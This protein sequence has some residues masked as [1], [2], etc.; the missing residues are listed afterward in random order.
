MAWA[1]QLGVSAM[2]ALVVLLVASPAAHAQ[3]ATGGGLTVTVGTSSND[4]PVGEAFYYGV[5]VSN[6]GGS[7]VSA[8]VL[9]V[10]FPPS[11]RSQGAVPP[12]G[13]IAAPLG[14]ACP[15][16]NLAA[17][18][19]RELY[20]PGHFG[21]LDDGA[22]IATVRDASGAV[23]VEVE[24][25]DND[26]D[27][28]DRTRHRRRGPSGPTC[29]D[30]LF[31]LSGGPDPGDRI[32]V[33]DDLEMELRTP[34]GF[35]VLFFNDNN[36][37]ADEHDPI[38][39]AADRGFTLQVTATNSTQ[40]GGNVELS[41]LYLHC[42]AT[43]EFQ[44]FDEDGHP[45]TCCP[46][47][48]EVFYDETF[49]IEFSTGLSGTNSVSSQEAKEGSEGDESPEGDEPSEGGESTTDNGTSQPE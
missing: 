3:T 11:F 5:R 8:A 33:D 42:E 13:C 23:T 10:I 30:G 4:P 39:F 29:P 21:G 31:T 24:R 7:P 49:T 48:G 32:K 35:S 2:A 45:S 41:P 36:D 17:G 18:E 47:G 40:H 28:D 20:F 38:E 27:D 34:D 46:P 14:L 37:E 16:G 9:E 15:L 12:S 26:G 19:T 43:G 22:T 25:Q 6:T 44:V 1:K